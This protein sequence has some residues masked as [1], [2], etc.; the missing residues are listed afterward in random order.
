MTSDKDGR[1]KKWHSER[2]SIAK[3][4]QRGYLRSIL[5]TGRR[6]RRQPLEQVAHHV[7]VRTPRLSIPS[8]PSL[9]QY[10]ALKSK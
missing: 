6:D 9:K 3:S 4:P 5:S 1:K 2:S 10:H 7:Q 8:S